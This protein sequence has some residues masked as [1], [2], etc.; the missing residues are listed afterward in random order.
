MGDYAIRARFEVA[1]PPHSVMRWL[2]NAAGIAG[3]WS[4]RVEGEAGAIGETFHVAFPTTPVIFDL[5]VRAASE[6]AVEWHVPTSPPWWKGSTIRFDL[7]AI[8]DQ[9]TSLL[10]T[11]RGFDPDDAIIEVITPAWV[12]FLDNLVAVAESG[13]PAPAV[14]NS[15]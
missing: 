14:V 12:R 13:R 11:H 3:W 15:Q 1:C 10:F 7:A 2:D 4:D 9:K 8:E 6:D 5:E